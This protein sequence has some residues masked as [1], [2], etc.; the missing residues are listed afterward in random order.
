MGVGGSLDLMAGTFS[1][2]PLWMQT[3][4]L[5]WF[6]RA[7]QEPGRLGKRYCRDAYGLFRHLPGQLAATAIKPRNPL[8][9]AVQVWRLANTLIISVSGNLTDALREELKEHLVFAYDQDLHVI[10][11]L[12]RVAY[13]GPDTLASLLHAAVA[14][15]NNRR[16]LL[17]A[18]M[19][20]HLQRILKAARLMHC[21]LIAP[22]VGDAVYR[23]NRGEGRV[24]SEVVAFTGT[25]VAARSIHV[26]AEL[27]KDF[28]ERII[29]VGIASQYLFGRYSPATPTS[30]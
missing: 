3:S 11:D 19:P 6:Y 9:S 30:H 14:M 18:E 7:S 2:A 8:P 20:T 10:V 23:V 24:P 27:L 22:T 13:L 5:E 28:C 25:A 26:Q 21:F 1:R 17:L 29:S 4:G 15:N 16:Q 12:A